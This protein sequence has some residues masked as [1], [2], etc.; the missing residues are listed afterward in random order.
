MSTA[1]VEVLVIV[2]VPDETLSRIAAIDPRVRV[3]DARGAFD[4]E[5]GENWSQWTVDRYLSYRKITASS[6]EERDRM[7]ATAEVVL[8][9]WPPL[10]NLRSRTPRLRWFHQ[11][12]AGAS[13]LLRSDLWGSDVTVTTS[14]GY[15]NTR[16][17]AEYVLA[18]FYDFARELHQAYHDR[19]QHHFEHRSYR[20]IVLEGKTVCVVGAGGIGRDVGQ[21]CASVGMHVIGTRR[22]VNPGDAL[23]PGFARLEPP[24]RLLAMLPESD[25]VAICCQWTPET[26]K[27]IGREVFA[28]MK[29][30]AILVNV[31]RGE[32]IDEEALIVAL[33][34]GKL[35][36]VGLDVYV[37]EFDHEPDRRLWDDDRV[38]IT[39][40]VSGHNDVG[41]HRGVDL[42]CE[43][44]RAYLDGRPLIN[45]IDWSVGY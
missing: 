9:G 19:V 45:V 29:P 1:D 44:L 17:M 14:R 32:I 34:E 43:N 25:C 15:G 27:L 10:L 40:H 22:R 4:A 12:P 31:A 21:L 13:N 23:P 6:R 38:L 41:Q 5:I 39:P 20:P 26:T 18:C 11:T 42:F 30:G 33:G 16:A 28:A 24:G 37:G 8:G 2:P 35:R 7:L 3:V 36:G